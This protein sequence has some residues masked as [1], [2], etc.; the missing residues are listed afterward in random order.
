MAPQFTL[1]RL[2]AAV[3]LI[4]IALALMRLISH[5]ESRWM[6]LPAIIACGCIGAAIDLLVSQGQVSLEPGK[7][8]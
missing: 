1:K 6:A 7:T 5:S 8:P 2:M 4:A 3:T